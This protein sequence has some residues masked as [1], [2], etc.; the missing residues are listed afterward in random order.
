MEEKPKKSNRIYLII[1][2]VLALALIGTGG[3]LAYIKMNEE[4][5]KEPTTQEEEK[6]TEE[7]KD[8]IIEFDSTAVDEQLNKYLT[9]FLNFRVVGNPSLF[10]QDLLADAGLRGDLVNS[11]FREIEPCEHY[12]DGPIQP[13]PY[14]QREIYENKY[15]EFYGKAD[16]FE[17]DLVNGYPHFSTG[18]NYQQ[19]I[20]TGDYIVWNDT[21][22]YT[23]ISFT[24][25]AEQ[26]L[27][28]AKEKQYTLSGSYQMTDENPET[29]NGT[30][31]LV[32]FKDEQEQNH[33]QS[34]IINE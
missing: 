12:N 19:Y 13:F 10:G 30:F 22:G 11:I 4:E 7:E 33:I 25:H 34:L 8:K 27:Y 16:L 17:Q 15:L 6:D 14:V 29:K 18:E 32:Y 1:V 21:W 24:L 9:T 5:K 2:V 23:P 28:Q 20:G 31:T 3:Y 26:I